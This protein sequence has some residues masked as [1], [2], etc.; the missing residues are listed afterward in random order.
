MHRDHL[1]WIW[2]SL[3]YGPGSVGFTEVLEKFGDPYSAYIADERELAAK[4]GK[5][6]PALARLSS[7]DLREAHR[8]YDFCVAREISLLTYGDISYPARLK[9]IQDPPVLLYYRGELPAFDRKLCI[10]V[11]GTR[12]MSE[13]GKRMAYR[14]SYELAASNAVVVSGL[15]LGCDAVAAAGVIA[16]GGTT[17]AV[18]GC[19]IDVVYPRQHAKLLEEVCRHGAVMTEYPPGTEPL[20]RNFPVRNRIISGLCQGT[21]AVEGDAKSGA[22]LTVGHAVKQGRKVFAVPGN[23]GL[24]S[25]EGPNELI[26]KGATVTLDAGDILAEF[27]VTHSDLFDKKACEAAKRLSE[28]D[29][30][31]LSH[32]GVSSRPVDFDPRES[33]ASRRPDREEP[34]SAPKKSPAERHSADRP[35]SMDRPIDRPASV[36][37]PADRPAPPKPTGRSADELLRER[38]E[39]VLSHGA[40]RIEPPPKAPAPREKAAGDDSEAILA[41]LREIER[42]VFS[43][44]PL[45]V[46][47]SVDRLGATGIPI[48]EIIRSL[49][50]LEVKGLI[51][52]LPGGLYLKK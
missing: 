10:G 23:V 43:E 11:V 44:M 12:K 3:L 52:S 14:I 18:L 30:V 48:G 27:E 36:D 5:R 8:I 13:Y 42:R 39:T 21:L 1:Y 6:S 45:D 38:P 15:A 9:T 26:R 49:T 50:V 37:R 16:A 2:L 31:F 19:G 47:V 33:R 28:L 32:L 46:A 4:L 51:T 41:S 40:P 34:R 24:P 25:S 22:L 29:S 35:V 7:K 17:V 20:G